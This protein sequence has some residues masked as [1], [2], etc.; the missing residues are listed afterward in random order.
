MASCQF[1]H[2]SLDKTSAI[3]KWLWQWDLQFK[4]IDSFRRSKKK[5]E[6]FNLKSRG[7][8]SLK[9]NK[10]K[11]KRW[12][13][14]KEPRKRR[15][16]NLK[17]RERKE[18]NRMVAC[19]RWWVPVHRKIRRQN[20]LQRFLSRTCK[21]CFGKAWTQIYPIIKLTTI[22]EIKACLIVW[23][24]CSKRQE[25]RASRNSMAK[26]FSKTRWRTLMAQYKR[27]KWCMPSWTISNF[28]WHEL[29]SHRLWL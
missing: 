2:P 12:K 24:N 7:R 15:R 4:W 1:T 25:L 8:R 10:P 18:D 26:V 9:L 21:H 13:R 27:T 29:I 14:P 17:M 6:G 16:D 5:K 3:W 20:R 23:E 11:N 22:K 19:N 28:H